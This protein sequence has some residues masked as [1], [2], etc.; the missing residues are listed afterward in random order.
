LTIANVAP[1]SALRARPAVV[2]DL[3][4]HTTYS[5]GR[6][7]PAELVAA[8]AAARLPALAVTDHDVVSGLAEAL[9]AGAR[10][11][12]EVLPG[13]ELSAHWDGRVCHILG[14]AF[15]LGNPALD[16]ALAAA[17]A[18][19]R[20]ATARGLE[21]LRAR[22][23]A[24]TAE[25][26]DR[27][28]ARYRTP[29]MLLLAMVQRRLLR[30]RDDLRTLLLALRGGAPSWT[31]A[32]AIAL[33]HRAGGVAVLAHPGRRGRRGPFPAATIAALAARGLDGIEVYHPAHADDLATAYADLA[34]ELGL[35]TT[36]GSDWHGRAHDPALG[37]LG[38]DA[39]QFA[40]LRARARTRAGAPTNP[41]S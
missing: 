27:Y 39:H 36:G 21:L 5:D 17:S 26:L 15:T 16:A 3:H 11:G 41:T 14:Y 6:L 34:A 38:V 25:D 1:H 24:L 8:A 30:S 10:L 9:D 23:H 40:A 2:A 31:A 33:I 13:I 29:T 22:G 7:P 19:A 37:S 18:R 35:L 4:T 20:A 12:V 28:R 32:E